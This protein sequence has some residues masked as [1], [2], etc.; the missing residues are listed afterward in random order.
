MLPTITFSDILAIFG[1]GVVIGILLYGWCH[2]TFVRHN[3]KRRQQ[4]V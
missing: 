3:K 4:P 1:A 2:L